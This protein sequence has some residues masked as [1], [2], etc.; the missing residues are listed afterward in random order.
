VDSARDCDFRLASILGPFPAAADIARCVRK[1]AT[2]A[3]NPEAAEQTRIHP[4]L[5]VLAAGPCR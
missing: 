5:V 2:I 3:W 4:R 1:G